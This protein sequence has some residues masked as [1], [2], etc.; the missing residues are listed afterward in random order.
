MEKY[1]TVVAVFVDH[2]QAEAAV[3]KLAAIGFDKRHISVVGKAYHDDAKFAGFYGAGD[4]IKF[5]GELGA[6]WGGLWGWLGGLVLS[7][8]VVGH[9]IALGAFANLL[10]SVIESAIEG[11]VGGAILAG[12]LSALG[13]AFYGMGI[14]EGSA[15]AYETHVKANRFLVMAGGSAEEVERARVALKEFNP[16][17]LDL[18]KGAK[19]ADSGDHHAT[20]PDQKSASR[21]SLCHILRR[22]E[23]SISRDYSDAS[24]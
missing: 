3:K 19:T 17:R 20:A 21:A 13:A 6:F 2:E 23:G 1:D 8:P 22:F 5:W 10:I 18:H 16:L 15:I 11:A 7:L 12:G 9:F 24:G 4:R 14:P